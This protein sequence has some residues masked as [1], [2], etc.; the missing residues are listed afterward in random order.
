MQGK[1]QEGVKA[2]KQTLPCSSPQKSLE[3]ASE[4]GASAWLTTLPI[5]EH[6]FSLHKQAFRDALC[7]RYGWEP[8]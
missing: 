1:Q 3:L 4:K 2:L 5:E 7:V 6:G 8:T